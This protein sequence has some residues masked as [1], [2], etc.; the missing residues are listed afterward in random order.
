MEDFWC[1]I[2]SNKRMRMKLTSPQVTGSSLYAPWFNDWILDYAIANR[3]VV[4]SPNYRLLPEA[5]GRDILDDIHD[6]WHWLRNTASVDGILRQTGYDGISLDRS[7]ILLIGESAGMVPL[8]VLFCD[9][10]LMTVT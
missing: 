2:F 7:S 5:T 4:I 9:E 8:V 1:V 6:F 3:A 10:Q